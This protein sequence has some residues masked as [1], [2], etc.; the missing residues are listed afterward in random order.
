MRVCSIETLKHPV[1]H[2][3]TA[4]DVS[5][6]VHPSNGC[7]VTLHYQHQDKSHGTMDRLP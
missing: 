3:Y 1:I 6:N 7:E 5:Q 4:D 2:R